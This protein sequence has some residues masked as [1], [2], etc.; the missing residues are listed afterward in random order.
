MSKPKFEID[1]VNTDKHEVYEV[2]GI[3]E[4]RSDEIVEIAIS[5]YKNKEFFSDTL[6]DIVSQMHDLNE[7]VFATLCAAKCH[8]Q[9]RD[10]K[11][12][13]KLEAMETLLELLK[14]KQ[15]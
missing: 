7:V 8:Q 9:H 11:L 13:K 3:S 4:E 12:T 1:L 10:S 6:A 15:Q 14:F 5:A 2:F